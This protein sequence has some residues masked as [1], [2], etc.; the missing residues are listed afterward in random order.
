[1]KKLFIILLVFGLFH[2]DSICQNKYALPCKPELLRKSD[3]IAKKQ[4]GVR[5]KTG[6]NDGIQV[7]KYLASVGRYRGEAYCMAGQYWCFVEAIRKLK[8]ED[9]NNLFHWTNDDIPIPKTG[10][11][12]GAY[13]YAQQH[14]ELVEYEPQVNDL[15]VWRNKGESSGHV[16]RI[17]KVLENG[18]VMTVGFNT[19]NGKSGSQA[20]GNG[21]FIRY[22]NV[23]HPLSRILLIRGLVGFVRF[24]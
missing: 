21:V 2:F 3:S 20:E 1:M 8:E 15:I 14:G 18:W 7:E 11:A 17:I 4:V 10:L 19:S 23:Y 22:R 13:N 16:E 24:V 9:I 5:E 12:N 6:H